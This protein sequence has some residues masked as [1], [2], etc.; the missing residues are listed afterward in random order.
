M[1]TRCPATW[2]R[3]VDP[4]R[5]KRRQHLG[6]QIQPREEAEQR[7]RP[8]ARI[9]AA[10]DAA[11]DGKGEQTE[12]ADHQAKDHGNDVP[13]KEQLIHARRAREIEPEAVGQVGVGEH[14]IRVG[15]RQ[16]HRLVVGHIGVGFVKKKEDGRLVHRH[17]RRTVLIGDERVDGMAVDDRH[18]SR[19]QLEKDVVR[20]DDQLLVA[21]ERLGKNAL[22]GH[23]PKAG[24]QHFAVDGVVPFAAVDGVLPLDEDFMRLRVPVALLCVAVQRDQHHR[25]D[26]RKQHHAEC[27]IGHHPPLEQ[28]HLR[29]SPVLFLMTSF[30]HRM[31]ALSSVQ[32]LEFRV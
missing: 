5:Q 18:V 20:K 15:Q 27:R 28:L 25:S 30:Y 2:M 32:F 26:Q 17:A 1:L 3:V 31:P 12:K 9:D 19:F 29:H 7:K 24:V 16:R 6:Q 22:D 14:R 4:E 8:V 21:V 10:D 11:C 23:R 13:R